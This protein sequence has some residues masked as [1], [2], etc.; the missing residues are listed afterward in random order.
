MQV[1]ILTSKHNFQSV[2]VSLYSRYNEYA[3]I[4][5]LY[6]MHQCTFLNEKYP[7]IKY[8]LPA[9]TFRLMTAQKRNQNRPP[10]RRVRVG[11]YIV[12]RNPHR[13]LEYFD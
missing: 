2:A 10:D 6:E 12:M 8:G 3:I 1:Y 7:I 13:R 11:V 5:A 4:E 9:R